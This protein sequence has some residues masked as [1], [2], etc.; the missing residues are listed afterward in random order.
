MT[1]HK[2]TIISARVEKG[3]NDAM[4]ELADTT[5]KTKSQLV[6]DAVIYLLKNQK[7]IELD[8]TLEKVTNRSD[9]YITNSNELLFIDMEN[10]RVSRKLKEET[11]PMFMDSFLS[12]ILMSR[13]NDTHLS[14]EDKR[15]ILRDALKVMKERAE[16]HDM[17]EE[18][19]H[20]MEAP[21]KYA[22][23]YIE[24]DN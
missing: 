5:E 12:N 9:V 18:Y 16:H 22:R 19:E 3:I 17:L 8:E 6:K 11:F 2:N 20:R 24:Q 1:E 13:R 4:D 23:D 14:E 21:L 15:E 10:K 7:A